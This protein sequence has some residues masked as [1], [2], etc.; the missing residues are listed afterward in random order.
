MPALEASLSSDDDLDWSD[1]P[2]CYQQIDI[3]PNAAIKASFSAAF[4]QIDTSLCDPFQV[5]PLL[6]N[7]PFHRPVSQH[8]LH[9]LSP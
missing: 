7:E 1:L 6:R 8:I 9:E 2:E 3:S 5:R 4:P